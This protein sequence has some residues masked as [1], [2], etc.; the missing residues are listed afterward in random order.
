MLGNLTIKE[1]ET[2]M[3]INFPEDIKKYMAEN[4]QSEA[5]KVKYG[6]W[7]CF[8][9]PFILV[10]GD[11]GTA[12]KIYNSVQDKVDECKESLQFSVNS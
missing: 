4:H 3:G 10:C 11:I 1:I 8:D 6:K 12:T 9:I 5:S 2:R 7:H